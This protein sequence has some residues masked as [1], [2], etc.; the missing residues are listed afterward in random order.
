MIDDWGGVEW[1]SEV[2]VKE[3]HT[4]SVLLDALRH[5]GGA[6]GGGVGLVCSGHFGGVLCL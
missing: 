3:G 6:G 2:K 5:L 4:G 1:I